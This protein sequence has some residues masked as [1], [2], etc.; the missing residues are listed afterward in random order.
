MMNIIPGGAVA[1][2]F[3]TYHN[4]LDMNLFM[5]IAPELYHKVTFCRQLEHPFPVNFVELK[6][7]ILKVF[8][9]CSLCVRYFNIKASY[10]IFPTDACGWWNGQSV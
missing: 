5:R 1:R 3:V 2:P 7:K 6:L 8:A 9:F 4:D 10:H